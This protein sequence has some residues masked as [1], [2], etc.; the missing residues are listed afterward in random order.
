MLR[1]LVA[2]LWLSLVLWCEDLA[3][4]SAEAIRSLRQPSQPRRRP[5][6]RPGLEALEVRYAPAGVTTVWDDST[7]NHMWSDA[8]NWSTNAVPTV[9]DPIQFNGTSNDPCTVD[10]TYAT[11]LT[12]LT[13]DGYG[14]TLMNS[15]GL[16]KV[17]NLTLK[18]GT[19]AG[20][21]GLEIATSTNAGYFDWEGGFLGSDTG[22]FTVTIDPNNKIAIT[23]TADKTLSACTVNNKGTASWT[24]GGNID[25][26]N[27]SKFET[28]NGA[29]FTAD[30][31]TGLFNGQ[32]NYMNTF[33]VDGGGTFT[34]N[35]THSF[36]AFVLNQGEFDINGQT[37]FRFQSSSIPGGMSPNPVYNIGLNASLNL[38]GEGE[39]MDNTTVIGSGTV[40]MSSDTL[41]IN[42]TVTMNSLSQTGGTITVNSG[43]T[44]NLKTKYTGSALLA[45][46]WDGGGTLHFLPGMTATL[47]FSPAGAIGL[48]IVND[49]T[50]TISTDWALSDGMTITNNGVMT[51][52]QTGDTSNNG[53]WTLSGDGSAQFINNGTLN[54]NSVALDPGEG[55]ATT[56]INT[57]FINQGMFNL[58][59][60][61]MVFPL[62]VWQLSGSTNLVGGGLQDQGT[63]VIGAGSTLTGTGSITVGT[64]ENDGTISVGSPSNPQGS[65]QV[66]GLNGVP[67]SGNYSQSFSG[68]LTLSLFGPPSPGNYNQLI[69]SGKASLA[70]TLNLNIMPGYTPVK[71]D[72]FPLIF[73]G[74]LDPTNNTFTTV[75]AGWTPTYGGT[76]FTETK[77]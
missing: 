76:G 28:W 7:G 3:W 14:G 12:S 39:T 73:W 21:G 69:I 63:Y 13:L 4:E 40:D 42:G 27:G 77:D 75:P 64:L 46:T 17:N 20:S 18:S 35:G 29:T 70:G 1:K 26:T 19:I 62:S 57:Q 60:G 9:N 33:Q 65:L 51:I 15:A 58:Q 10:V 52:T 32:M 59:A 54:I 22:N 53:G 2:Y 55:S 31:A 45:G 67:G 38:F 41:T 56:T 6:V 37:F 23:G 24:N 8:R 71:G 25:A 47:G 16:L 50:L 74:S 66:F 11:P 68:I 61:L 49:T 72:A 30:S 34:D 36:D 43:A 44:L 48:N 5:S